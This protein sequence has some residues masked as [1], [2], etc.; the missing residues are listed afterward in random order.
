MFIY[1]LLKAGRNPTRASLT[2]ALGG[3]R[4]WT[5]D[6]AFGPF[7]PNTHAG[8]ICYTVVH[9]TGNQFTRWFPSKGFYCHGKA[10]DVGPA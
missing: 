3:L 1:A 5:G 2:K 6:G 10:T 4:N 8:T 9:V 7:T